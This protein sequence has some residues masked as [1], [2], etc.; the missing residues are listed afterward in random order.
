MREC[1]VGREWMRE[2]FG[3]DR[4]A[5]AKREPVERAR[6]LGLMPT[7]AGSTDSLAKGERIGREGLVGGEKP[8]LNGRTGSLVAAFFCFAAWL[9]IACFM[10]DRLDFLGW[11]VGVCIGLSACALGAG[12]DGERRG[13]TGEAWAGG[14]LGLTLA[15][16]LGAAYPATWLA[17]RERFSPVNLAHHVWLATRRGVLAWNNILWIGAGADDGVPVREPAACAP[18]GV[19]SG[20]QRAWA[21]AAAGVCC[22]TSDSD[23]VSLEGD[24]EECA[25]RSSPAGAGGEG[26]EVAGESGAD[27][28]AGAG[29]RERSDQRRRGG[30]DADGDE[31]PDGAGA[32]RAESAGARAPNAPAIIAAATVWP[33]RVSWARSQTKTAAARAA[34]RDGHGDGGVPKLQGFLREVAVLAGRVARLRAGRHHDGR[35]EDERGREGTEHADEDTFEGEGSERAFGVG[36]GEDAIDLAGA[37]AGPSEDQAGRRRGPCGLPTRTRRGSR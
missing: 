12:G 35:P 19:V 23:Q 20:D 9:W 29:V 32:S 30:E 7:E 18:A 15:V 6:E 17:V 4:G 22:S 2:A 3:H 27:D 8:L 10:R 1:P 14:R 16:I 11:P 25:R 37:P 5:V 31:E 28:A 33:L 36:L 34:A 24:A 21:G 13:S 26:E